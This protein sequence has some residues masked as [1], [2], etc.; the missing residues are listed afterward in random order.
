MAK[1][2]HNKSNLESENSGLK[3]LMAG[4]SRLVVPTLEEKKLLLLHLNYPTI[5]T[6][7][8]DLVR[9]HVTS[10]ELVKSKDDF[11]L[12]EV[13]VTSKKL[14]NFPTGFFFGLTKNE[15]TLLQD[16]EGSFLLCLVSIHPDTQQSIYLDFKSLNDRIRNKRV[17]YQINL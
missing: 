16:L 3:L 10:I 8:F 5:Y 1:N 13:K 7:S 12:I 6:R 11:V 14:V 2:A 15:E 17:Q 4:D 9:L